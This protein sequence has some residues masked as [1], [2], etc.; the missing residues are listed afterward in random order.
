[1]R[2]LIIVLPDLV[3]TASAPLARMMHPALF[4]VVSLTVLSAVFLVICCAALFGRFCCL[5][6]S[7]VLADLL[8]TA[9][10]GA[11]ITAYL[12]LLAMV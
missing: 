4:S 6:L 11:G 5:G 12:I 1:M 9:I 2:C 7:A 3:S 10:I 8:A